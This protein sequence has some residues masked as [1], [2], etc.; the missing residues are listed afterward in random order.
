MS[1]ITA[2]IIF[3]AFLGCGAFQMMKSFQLRNLNTSLRK[4]DYETTEQ[5]AD[6]PMVRKLLGDYVCD[7]YALR[8]YNLSRNTER[9][10]QQLHKMLQKTYS[11]PQDKKGFLEEYYHMFLIDQ[12]RTYADWMLEGIRALGD[13]SCTQ[14]SEQAYEVMLNKRSD[15]I[16]QM[17]DEINSKKYYGFPLG[18]ILFMIG[19]QYEYREDEKTA[20][21][22]YQNA[23]VCFHPSAVYVPVLEKNMQRLGVELE[24]APPEFHKNTGK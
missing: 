6:M 5:L 9:L 18:V 23:K 17:I 22:Y 14:Y 19:Q 12:K 20:G 4:K 21:I 1:E 8:A 3:I 2:A 16:D 13:P 15:L 11:N 24:A 10:E 7:L